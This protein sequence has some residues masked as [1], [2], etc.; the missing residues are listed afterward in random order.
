[1]KS[2]DTQKEAIKDGIAGF[3][4]EL[5][6]AADKRDP[7]MLAKL[8]DVYASAARRWSNNNLCAILAQKPN[9]GKP[10][11]LS[12]AR[13]VG[14][15][16]KKEAKPAAIFVPVFV[17][18]VS[19]KFPE[20]VRL[21][22]QEYRDWLATEPNRDPKKP[23]TALLFTEQHPKYSRFPQDKRRPFA[24]ELINVFDKLEQ[25]EKAAGNVLRF[26][27]VPCV[28]DLGVETDGPE[29]STA[30]TD[31]PERMG[32][33][34]A[35]F[36]EYANE[37]GWSVNAARL[38]L[39]EH[40]SAS[41]GKIEIGEWISD[42][43]KVKVLAHEMAHQIL[44]I[45]EGKK[46]PSELTEAEKAV[47]EMQA[48]AVAYAVCRHFGVKPELSAEYLQSFNTGSREIMGHLK[49]ICD[50]SKTL[51]KGVSSHLQWATDCAQSQ[52]EAE[53]EARYYLSN[54]KGEDVAFEDY[55]ELVKAI[56]TS[57]MPPEEQIL[58]IFKAGLGGSFVK[59]SSMSGRDFVDE[60]FR[61][62]CSHLVEADLKGF[63]YND[64]G[65]FRY[66]PKIEE[67]PEQLRDHA[68]DIATV[69][70]GEGL[71]V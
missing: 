67:V 21:V 46:K 41:T 58:N 26:K 30:T 62:F 64:R 66:A 69:K 68:V 16:P 20:R 15:F 47:A 7:A 65:D 18:D 29:I 49:T 3:C 45:G 12:E 52:D 11:T 24:G 39:G 4:N 42:P 36:K 35:A 31:T 43:S 55:G 6:S 61:E 25:A 44:H 70:V 38:S 40:G 37:Q 2:K 63:A 19:Q 48:E 14:H 50:T 60:M 8:L 5:A 34:L 51:I 22:V 23:E 54:E 56:C 28:Y 9:I 71:T 33:L 59:D 10:V 32:E 13:K 27:T 1:M 53:V 57:S 17:G